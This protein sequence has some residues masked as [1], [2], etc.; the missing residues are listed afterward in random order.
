MQVT[1]CCAVKFGFMIADNEKYRALCRKRCQ[2]KDLKG[3]IAWHTGCFRTEKEW[4]QEKQS[5]LKSMD[6]R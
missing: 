1:Q 4:R 2:C 3:G 6:M 5:H